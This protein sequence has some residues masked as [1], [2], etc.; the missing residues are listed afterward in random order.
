MTKLSWLLD[1]LAIEGIHGDTDIEI[2]GITK[3]S[4]MAAEGYMFFCTKK[5]ASFIVQ[6]VK[7]GAR[8][9]VSE[10]EIPSVP[11]DC[12][13]IASNVE[14]LLGTV[15]SRF[16]GM[17]SRDLFIAGVTGTNGKTTTTYLMESIAVGAG[18]QAGIIGTISY[19]YG[20]RVFPAPN[21]TPGAVEMHSL[22][23]EMRTSGT[24]LVAMEVSS[25]AL[26][27]KRVE[28]VEFNMGI[29]T[30]LTHD[31]LDYHET[32]EKYAKAKELLFSH[33]LKDSSKEMK[34]AILNMDDPAAPGFTPDTSVETIYYSTRKEANAYLLRG[35][36]CIDGLS[37]EVSVMGERMSISSSLVGRFNTSNILAACLFGYGAGFSAEAVK[38][39]VESLHGVPGR[40][41]RVMNS[42]E[43]PVFIDYAHTPDALKKALELLT[44]LKKGRLIVV[45]GCG[46]DRDTTKRPIMG[47]IASHLADY[48]IVTSDNP[49]GE[50]PGIIIDDITAGFNG[51]PFAVIEDRREAIYQGI[52]MARENDVVLIAGKGHEDYQIVGDRKF[53][54][55]DMEIAK[56][57]LDVARR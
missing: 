23:N 51:G 13:I 34:W 50:K 36:E 18:K 27:Q 12:L 22:L 55:S 32:F 46:G 28:G 20:G 57:C 21:T 45:F 49:R 56:E 17:P 42:K 52:K 26:D 39:G 19:R 8:V 40:L 24:E 48:S 14:G 53:H 35:R 7:R 31:H 4:R 43:I 1:G 11:V 47:S 25:H 30:N 9:V 5:S 2:K 15:S 10:S 54:F 44:R 41:E 33:H 6:A 38:K 3:D 16:Y 29:F 37:L